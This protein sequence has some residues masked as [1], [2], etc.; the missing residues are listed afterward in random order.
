MSSLR[1]DP[2][3]NL[4]AAT[5]RN[6]REEREEQEAEEQ[7]A[8]AARAAQEATEESAKARADTAAKAQAEAAAAERAAEA[9]RNQPPQLVILLRTAAPD[10]PVP[11]PEEAGRDQPVRE[12]LEGDA[13]IL[14]RGATPPSPTGM[15]QGGRPDAPPE[16]PAG[17]DPAVRAD[18]VVLSP[19]RHC[20]GK[21]T[22]ASDPQ[23][24]AGSGPSAQDLETASSS[25]SGWTP[26]GGT[27]ALN[28]AAQDIRER[29]Q[30]QA[31]VL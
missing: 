24:V 6:T 25:S 12:R 16:Q 15:G 10:I 31:A 26:G 19:S 3:A 22:S 23:A 1:V 7:R 8:A 21:A 2:R 20:L 30:S 13:V 17:G 29:L 5:E 27:A 28:M 11:L 4:Q 14:E 18:L 9:L